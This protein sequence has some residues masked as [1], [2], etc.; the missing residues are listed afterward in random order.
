MTEEKVVG[1]SLTLAISL[2]ALSSCTQGVLDAGEFL[3]EALLSL[4]GYVMARL[5]IFAGR[6]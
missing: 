3:D 5:L 2:F 6:K 4:S 1:S